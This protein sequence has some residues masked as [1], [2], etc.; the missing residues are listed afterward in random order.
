MA[1]P[2]CLTEDGDTA[3]DESTLS[4]SGYALTA[5]DE[6]DDDFSEDADP[7]PVEHEVPEPVE[8][9]LDE[10]R[11]GRRERSRVGMSS[12]AL[13]AVGLLAIFGVETFLGGK[14]DDAQ[15]ARVEQ[16]EALR[17]LGDVRSLPHEDFKREVDDFRD[18]FP[19]SRHLATLEDHLRYTDQRDQHRELV[20][21]ELEHLLEW[22]AGIEPSDMRFRLQVLL[23]RLPGDEKFAAEVQQALGMLDRRQET[24]DG[25]AFDRLEHEVALALEGKDPGR[26]SR[27]LAA[28]R[29]ANPG[30]TSK[31]LDRLAQLQSRADSAARSVFESA[32]D[33]AKDAKTP[34]DAR[35]TLAAA[36][37]GL[38]GTDYASKI[39]ARLRELGRTAE[40]VPTAPGRGPADRPG[41]AGRPT[42][43]GGDRPESTPDVP[44][45][46]L[47]RADQAQT[48]LLA[49]SWISGRKLLEEV[50]GTIDAGRQKDE[51]TRLLADTDRI[52]ALTQQLGER[53]RGEKPPKRKLEVA[54]RVTVTD[55]NDRRVTVQTKDGEKKWLWSQVADEDVVDLLMPP[56]PTP[57]QRVAPVASRGANTP[58]AAVGD[59]RGRCV[60]ERCG[61]PG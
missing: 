4:Y 30:L 26:A 51:W 8:T 53:A 50:I 42:Q 28:F 35:R 5:D 3:D 6:S 44:L 54:G 1:L 22:P 9:T 52:L 10:P 29:Y 21:G 11:S 43:P 47:A 39:T 19:T 33:R 58:A 2:G 55:A 60:R 49:R 45:E 25:Q 24:L 7:E 40:P 27:M 12:I 59:H 31:T 34:S 32:W 14:A 23:R 20:E 46:I 41:A 18:R 36:H 13:V 61:E 17:I 37:V 48:L 38:A 57:E 16:R 56:R 15:Q